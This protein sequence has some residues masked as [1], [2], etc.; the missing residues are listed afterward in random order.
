MYQL[1][2]TE[3]SFNSKLQGK[4]HLHQAH[5]WTGQHQVDSGSPLRLGPNTTFAERERK[6]TQPYIYIYIMYI[7][8]W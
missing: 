8:V 3:L 4:L 7:Y 5:A 6:K 2:T 1:A